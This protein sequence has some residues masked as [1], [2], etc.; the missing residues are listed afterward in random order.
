MAK[1]RHFTAKIKGIEWKFYAQTASAYK[2]KHGSDSHAITYTKDR[3][4]YFNISTLATDYVRHEVFHS[5]I[6]SSSTNSAS[7]TADQMEEL[8]AELYGEHGPEMDLLVDQILNFF[9]R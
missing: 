5:Y 2:R 6:A 1:A 7:L 8:C 4:V 9:L 3:E